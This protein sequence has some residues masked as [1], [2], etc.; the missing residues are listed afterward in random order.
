MIYESKGFDG[1]GGS[2]EHHPQAQEKE[3]AHV[4]HPWQAKILLRRRLPKHP[5]KSARRR[6]TLDHYTV[7]T[8]CLTTESTKIETAQHT[9]VHC[10]WKA[11]EHQLRQAVRKLYDSDVA[12]V[13]V[14][15]RPDGEKKAY[16]PL[17]PNH[18]ALVL[19]TKLGSPKLSS[20]D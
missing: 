8:S 2:T 1:Q 19:P 15:I 16:V 13:N 17:V 20:A 18:D 6:D 7:I 11:N 3:E 12:E 5:R 10:R 4:T 9:C 14:L